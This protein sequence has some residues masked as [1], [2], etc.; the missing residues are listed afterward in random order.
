MGGEESGRESKE[1]GKK[2]KERKGK[3]SK[4]RK[5]EGNKDRVL[6]RKM[7]PVLLSLFFSS[8]NSRGQPTENCLQNMK[9]S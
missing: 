1:R 9:T 8:G 4:R 3:G 7:N 6:P 5:K 2:G